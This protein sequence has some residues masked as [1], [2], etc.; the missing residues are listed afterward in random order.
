MNENEEIILS[1]VKIFFLAIMSIIAIK[2]HIDAKKS[3][4]EIKKINEKYKQ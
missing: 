3:Y 4:E 2:M 1:I